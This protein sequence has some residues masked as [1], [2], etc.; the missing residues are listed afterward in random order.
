MMC[1]REK[2]LNGILAKCTLYRHKIYFFHRISSYLRT[3]LRGNSAFFFHR[4]FRVNAKK[5][6]LQFPPT[7]SNFRELGAIHSPNIRLP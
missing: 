3:F 4:S 5:C 2:T 7:K 1:E 6:F